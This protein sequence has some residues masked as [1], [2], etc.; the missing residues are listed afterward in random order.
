M[1]TD[2]SPG[3]RPISTWRSSCPAWWKR[4]LIGC[5][6]ALCDRVVV[7]SEDTKRRLRNTAHPFRRNVEVIYGAAPPAPRPPAEAIAAFARSFSLGPGP[8]VCQITRFY[9]PLKV[10]GAERLLEAFS[11]VRR[12]IPDAQLLLVGSGPLWEAFK[13]KHGL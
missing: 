2:S 4:T 5:L 11:V 12:A 9:Y 3:R 8:V 10:K 1:M 13:A 6:F 7:V